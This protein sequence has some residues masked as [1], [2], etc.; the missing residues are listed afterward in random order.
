MAGANPPITYILPDAGW[1]S[2]L[3]IIVRECPVRSVIEV[4]TLGMA[5]LAARMLQEVD[6]QVQHLAPDLAVAIQA[7][8]EPI[9]LARFHHRGEHLDEIERLWTSQ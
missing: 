5:T 1:A 3:E 6:R 9:T 4:N 8:G 7:A 2:L